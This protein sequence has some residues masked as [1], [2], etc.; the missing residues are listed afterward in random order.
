[1]N[2]FLLMAV[3]VF[4]GLSISRAEDATTTTSSLAPTNSQPIKLLFLGDSL[5]EGYGLPAE[6]AYPMLV[7]K[8]LQA[9]GYRVQVINGGE[10]GSTSAGG[11]SRLR[12]Y[13]RAKPTIVVVA[14]GGN[15]GLRG[16]AVSSL[17]KNL[18]EIITTSQKS[19]A[20]VLLAG[21]QIPTNYGET[22]TRDFRAVYPALAKELAVPLLPFLLE[23]V[24]GVPKF[25]QADGIHPTA[26]GQA[27]MAT[28][29]ERALTSHFLHR[30]GHAEGK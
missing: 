25:M 10:S 20:K 14:L 15:D 6:L 30:K 9:K 13:L 24:G 11:V 5:T 3:L 19:G 28:L 18:R 17:E 27:M 26:E 7:E 12:W 8:S 2:R 29:V 16:L 23:G 4:G 21:M 1:M 22:Y